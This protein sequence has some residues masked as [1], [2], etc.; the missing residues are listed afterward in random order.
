MAAL[1]TGCKIRANSRFTAEGEINAA[2]FLTL[3]FGVCV[4]VL[5]NNFRSADRLD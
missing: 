4:V 3:G 5:F 1:L 2:P